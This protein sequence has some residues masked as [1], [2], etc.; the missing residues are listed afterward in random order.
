LQCSRDPSLALAYFYFDMNDQSKQLVH[1]LISSL[2]QQFFRMCTVIPE[3]F[4]ALRSDCGDGLPSRMSLMKVLREIL[5]V[6]NHAYIILDAL[7]ECAE[8]DDLLL[9]LRDITN[10]HLNTHILVTSR[11]NAVILKFLVPRITHS[12]NLGSAP[13]DTDIRLWVHEQLQEDNRL[14]RWAPDVKE[15]IEASLMKGANGM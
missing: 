7:D 9:F 14:R 6:F 13:V 2:V 11:C 1:G 10:W 12:I 5:S 15:E 3:G 4:E 8:R